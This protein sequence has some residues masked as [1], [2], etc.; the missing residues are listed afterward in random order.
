[1]IVLTTSTLA[2][3]FDFIPSNYTQ[4]TEEIYHI[5]IDSET[6]NK[7]IST[8]VWEQAFELSFK[9]RKDED[10]VIDVERNLGTNW[11]ILSSSL[12]YRKK[13]AFNIKFDV[14][15]KADSETKLKFRVRYRYL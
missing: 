8:K 2:Q 3:S 13:D 7:Q 4:S 12:S 5:T 15:V 1:M 6:E 10:V 11:E 14:P 9:N